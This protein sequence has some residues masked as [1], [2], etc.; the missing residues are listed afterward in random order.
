MQVTLSRKALKAAAVCSARK[1]IRYYLNGVNVSFMPDNDKWWAVYAATEGHILFT[2]KAPCNKDEGLPP[3]SLIIPF[4]VVKN[5]C[6]GS[7]RTLDGIFLVTRDNGQYQ[8]GDVVFTPID[9]KF[10]DYTRVIPQTLSGVVAQFNPYLLAQGQ[11]AL[12]TW[13][14]NSRLTCGI[15]HNGD[16]AGVMGD[17]SDAVV[18]VMPMRYSFDEYKPFEFPRQDNAEKQAA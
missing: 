15:Q 3:E 8:L 12:Q 11:N 5:A 13:Q 7:N 18:V 10:P 4:D 6:K 9:G 1:D 14:D 17:L 2:G 16:S